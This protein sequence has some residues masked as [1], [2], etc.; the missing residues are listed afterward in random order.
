MLYIL[1]AL[2]VL[3]ILVSILALYSARTGHAPNVRNAFRT[4][5]EKRSSIT[6][7]SA[8]DNLKRAVSS[9]IQ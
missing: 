3:N 2:S 8:R 4:L 5:I 1:V 6:S 7:P 9:L